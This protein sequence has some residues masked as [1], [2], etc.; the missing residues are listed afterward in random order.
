MD[1]E[2]CRYS[3]SPYG[4]PAFVID[5][6]F[7]VSTPKR[8]VIDY[9][10]TIN[11]VTIKDPFPIDK[12]DEMIKKLAGKKYISIVDIKQAFNNIKIKEED[13]YKTA[14]VTPDHHIEF[15]RIKFGLANA[16]AMLARAISE[17]YGNL[18]TI[19]LTKY[20]DDI[21]DGHDLFEDLLDFLHKHFEA[22]RKHKLK[23]TR[24]KCNF[25]VQKV[26]LLG[27]ILDE[28]GDH[29]DPNRIKSVQR[30]KILDTIHEVRSFLGFA[31]TLRRYIK[32]FA[33][34]SSF[35]LNVLKKSVRSEIK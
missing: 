12:M 3:N 10:R 28:D 33:V 29:P 32:K 9:S 23:F 4:A 11:P 26:K 2:V 17:A 6:P 31:N 30:Y 16:P 8:I 7:H 34:I 27:R 14:A 20:Y 19:G 24:Q 21:D 18:Q 15:S 5:Q 35:L 1:N 22:T 13:I 25:A